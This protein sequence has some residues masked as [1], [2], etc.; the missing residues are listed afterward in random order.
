MPT[1]N[2]NERRKIEARRAANKA[3][4]DEAAEREKRTAARVQ[5]ILDN[6]LGRT[7]ERGALPDLAE[8]I[9]QLDDAR[10]V[11]LSTHPPQAN[12]AVNATR[13]MSRLLGL[14]VDRS[15]VA[16]GSPS[17][18]M[19]GDVAD[20]KR[21]LFERMSERV[22]SKKAQ[23]ML[24]FIEKLRDEPDDDDGEATDVEE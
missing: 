15:V 21:A 6:A 3:A 5:G 7:R 13:A 8:L 11:A 23:R 17:E 22:G 24:A 10:M 4:R 20:Q 1:P 18:F 16:V 19:H 9:S 12:A 14:L 2:R